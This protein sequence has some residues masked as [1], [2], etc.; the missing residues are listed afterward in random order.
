MLFEQKHRDSVTN[1]NSN[2][3]PPMQTP[4][5]STS[6]V[7]QPVVTFPALQTQNTTS[8]SLK[9][10]FDTQLNQWVQVYCPAPTEYASYPLNSCYH[11]FPTESQLDLYHQLAV[12]PPPPP[13]LNVEPT[14]PMN[15]IQLS[16][17][18]FKDLKN[19]V[20]QFLPAS[21][22]T[23]VTREKLDIPLPP[24][25]NIKEKRKLPPN[26]KHS[27]N[28]EGRIY[29]YNK[30]TK[31]SQWHFPCAED[32]KEDL[33]QSITSP[34][35]VPQLE[36]STTSADMESSTTTTIVGKKLRESLREQ[37]SKLVIKLLQPYMKDDCKFGHVTNNDDFKHLA[38]KFT[39]SILEKELGRM[40]AA[41]SEEVELTKR[42]KIK[43]H[44]Y[45]NKYMFKFKGDYTR[46][47]DIDDNV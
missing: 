9:W 46:K 8:M 43:A 22:E 37:L 20:E 29:Y 41:E 39:H 34:P 30:L 26:W 10:L 36:P 15:S 14:A 21:A 38:R 25:K 42:V 5:S 1:L 13:P 27:R 40:T 18:H 32:Q 35:C 11:E 6:D 47:T 3:T 19:A 16:E 7:Q 23:T 45:I 12:A 28:S 4:P 33:K 44:E 31:K 24:P 17:E 2:P